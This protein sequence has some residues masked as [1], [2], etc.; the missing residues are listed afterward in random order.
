MLKGCHMLFSSL[1]LSHGPFTDINE[2][3]LVFAKETICDDILQVRNFV[4][5]KC[6]QNQQSYTEF[7]KSSS[8][9]NL[10]TPPCLHPLG[11]DTFFNFT[12]V[13]FRFPYIKSILPQASK[14]GTSYFE[15]EHF[16]WTSNLATSN[17]SF[18]SNRESKFLM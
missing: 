18:T 10:A 5:E 2:F 14:L 4:G 3:F 12:F 11:T 16:V 8:N 1:R 15:P 9:V 6:C 7:Y 13:N 17:H